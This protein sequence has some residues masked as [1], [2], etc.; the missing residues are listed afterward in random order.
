MYNRVELRIILIGEMGVGKKSI[1]KRFKMLNCSELKLISNNEK[2]LDQNKDI[3]NNNEKTLIT[4][5]DQKEKIN[6][7]NEDIQN[8]MNIRIKREEKRIELMNF[9]L[10]YKI[11]MN[12]LEIRFYPCI[13]EIPLDYDYESKEED[14]DLLELEKEYK[15]SLRPLIQEIKNIILNPPLN[16][17]NQLEYLFLLCFDMNNFDSFKK[18]LIYYE[19]IEKKIGISKN[20]KIALIGNK[21]DK[22][23]NINKEDIITFKKSIN[24]N[25]YEISTLM[26]FP[27]DKFFENLIRDNIKN[28]KILNDRDD[29]SEFHQILIKKNNFSKA[30]RK[31]GENI[32]ISGEIKFKYNKDI[33]E[34]PSNIKSLMKIFQDPDKFNKNIFITKIG[35]SLPPIKKKLKEKDYSI[36]KTEENMLLNKLN[37]GISVN[38]KNKKIQEAIELECKKPGYSFGFKFGNKTLNLKNKRKALSEARYKELD[39]LLKEYSTK[40]F[41][42]KKNINKE[43]KSQK[44]YEE[45]RID[46]LKKKKDEYKII[47]NEMQKRHKNAVVKNEENEKEKL[48]KI[49]EKEKKYEKIYEENKKEKEKKRINNILKN[50]NS[51]NLNIMTDESLIKSKKKY[52]EPKAKFYTPK[53]YIL[54]DKGFTFGHKFYNPEKN[55][56]NENPQFPLFVDD[57]EKILLKNKKKNYVST[58]KRFSE[59]KSEEIDDKIEKKINISQEKFRKNREKN[60][61]NKNIIFKEKQKEKKNK[62]DK[63]KSTIN[64]ENEKYLE[65][66]INKIYTNEKNYLNREINYNL[67]ENSAPKYSFREKT[68]FGS[69]FAKDKYDN[70]DDLD[71]NK[72]STKLS[73][74]Y[75]DNP[76]VQYTHPKFPKF[77][78]G[79]SKRFNFTSTN[80]FNNKEKKYDLNT[81]DYKYTQSFLKAQTYMGTAKKLEVKYN[82]I[83]GPNLY[84]IKRFADDIVDKNKKPK[85]RNQFFETK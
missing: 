62:V 32:G 49:I 42:K 67:V 65:Y 51:I 11:K 74:L 14:D 61:L 53:S 7:N 24:A 31:V 37:K 29:A 10:I 50:N 13:E 19:Q 22:K 17:N 1:V 57:F 4:L 44:K 52:I 85:E 58:S 79:K 70:D 39:D 25:Y 43:F 47:N 20:F 23:I 68:I 40:L 2:E 77:S 83:P 56:K 76:D 41:N 80:D 35:A 84:K 9:S 78:F 54:T 6:I 59:Y 18:L 12:Y 46:I 60:L 82:G 30:E 27:F 33:Y 34:Y 48:D 63:N 16:S 21:L 64:K 81:T 26:F 75:L 45:N 71:D 15:F 55:K 38:S 72:K 3:N 73:S 69:I 8:D 36:F 5:K 66:Y 28:L